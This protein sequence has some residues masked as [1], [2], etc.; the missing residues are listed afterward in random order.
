MPTT[1]ARAMEVLNVLAEH[2]DGVTVSQLAV[3]L[4]MNATSASRMVK[5]LRE[6][7]AVA[8]DEHSGRLFPGLLLW[9][10]GASAIK[11]QEFRRVAVPAIPSAIPSLGRS[12]NL[13]VPMPDCVLYIEHLDAVGNFIS[14]IPAGLRMPYHATTMGKAILAFQKPEVIERVLKDRLTRYTDDTITDPELLRQELAAIR[15]CGFALNRGEYHGN[16][17]GIAVPLLTSSGESVAAI[18]VE[19]LAVELTPDSDVVQSMVKLGA[20]ISNQLGYGEVL[21]KFSP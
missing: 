8:R 18:S 11:R 21:G 5:T 3:Q 17:R 1:V 10:L 6:A 7:G 16:A 9:A 12:A 19:A 13:G 20:S 4:S 2:P 15:E 14:S